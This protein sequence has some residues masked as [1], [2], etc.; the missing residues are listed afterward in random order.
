MEVAQVFLVNYY[1]IVFKYSMYV[2]EGVFSII[3]V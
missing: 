1:V 3:K 2:Q